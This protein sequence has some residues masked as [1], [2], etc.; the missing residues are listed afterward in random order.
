MQMKIIVTCPPMLGMIEEFIPFAAKRGFELIPAKVTQT[1]SQEELVELVPQYDGWIIGD[2]P[3]TRRVFEAGKAGKLK[4][5]V[6][7]G[8]GVRSE[9][10][11]SELQSLMRNSYAVFCLKKKKNNTNIDT[12][13]IYAQIHRPPHS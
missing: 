11:T 7:R 12:P 6:K 2:D 5:A 9:E 8:I 1:L 10:H 4:A 13:S 3:A